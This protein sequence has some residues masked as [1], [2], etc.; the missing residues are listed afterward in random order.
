MSRARNRAGS[1]PGSTPCSSC[2]GACSPT[3]AAIE[4]YAHALDPS[5]P[6]IPEVTAGG[7]LHHGRAVFEQNCEHCHGVDGG[8]ASVGGNQWAP[9]LH[10]TSITQVAE[11]IRIGPGEM[12]R[13]GERQLIERDLRDV[14]SYVFKLDTRADERALPL[15]SSGPVPEGLLGWLAITLLSVLALAYSKSR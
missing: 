8:G 15:S 4:A 12:P 13:F 6:P 10:D 11:A 14:A 2:R 7:E 1:G 9:A 3:I 5:G